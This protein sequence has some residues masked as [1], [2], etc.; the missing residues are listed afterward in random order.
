MSN[1]EI[2]RIPSGAGCDLQTLK[3]ATEKKRET[4]NPYFLE[5]Q[6]VLQ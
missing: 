5:M 3:Y 2:N 6:G 4:N 1:P